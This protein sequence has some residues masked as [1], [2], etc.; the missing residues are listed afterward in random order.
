MP[1]SQ[2]NYTCRFEWG[3]KG[4]RDAAIRGDIVIIVDVLS[5]SSTT[6]MAVSH[7]A[8][9]YP[10]P[11]LDH[12][13]EFAKSVDATL[14]SQRGQGRSLSPLSFTPED[15]QKRY[16][17][18]S[19]NGGK[20]AYIARNAPSVFVGCLLNA[21]VVAET[22]AAISRDRK[23][24]VTVVA[25]GELWRDVVAEDNGLR[26]SVEDYLGAGAIISYLKGSKSP[27]AKVCE[28]AFLYA[29]ERLSQFIWECGSGLELREKGF[30]DDVRHCAKL[31]AVEVAP[32]MVD[33]HFE[34]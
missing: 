31:N 20:C 1:F 14:A 21:E 6:T 11:A 15:K 2:A 24:A 9:I 26:P 27:E 12:A 4:A 32:L 22:A 3:A 29:S 23:Q 5:F 17:L 28:L 33:D 10:Y 18:A 8:W 7:G 13:A 30:A 25:C 16:V 34:R 19:P